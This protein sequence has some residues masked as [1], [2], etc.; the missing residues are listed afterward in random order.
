MTKKLKRNYVV[1]KYSEIVEAMYLNKKNISIDTE[2]KLQDGGKQ[3]IK[4]NLNVIE[5]E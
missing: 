5:L 3:K 4:T 2:I 1:E